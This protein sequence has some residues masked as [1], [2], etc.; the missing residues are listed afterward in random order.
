VRG[1]RREALAARWGQ[2]ALPFYFAE[3]GDEGLEGG[4]GV[5]V[6]GEAQEG[7]RMDGDECGGAV[8][9]G[10]FLAAGIGEAEGFAEDGLGGGDA[11]A[12]DEVGLDGAEFGFEPGATGGDFAGV[13]F[14]ME[15]A[16]AARLPFEVFDG[17]GDVERFAVDAGGA[18]CAIEELAGGADEGFSGA[19]FLVAGLFA[20][21]EDA[22]AGRTL[23]EDRAGGA[24]PEWTCAA[25]RGRGAE[26]REIGGE[27]DGRGGKIG[28]A[29][30]LGFA[31]GDHRGGARG[32]FGEERRD[33][34]GFGEISPVVTRHL[35][36]HGADFDASGVEDAG[37]I[38]APEVFG[39]VGGGSGVAIG[40][41][42]EGER[43]AVPMR[44]LPGRE[45]RP[46]HG[47]EAIDEEGRGGFEDVV[48]RFEPRDEPRAGVGG[49]FAKADERV[50]FVDLAPDGFRHDVERGDVG[51][52]RDFEQVRLAV[53]KTPEHAVEKWPAG[54]VAVTGDVAGEREK[55][56]RDAE[57]GD[58]VFRGGRSV[59][60]CEREFGLLGAAVDP[61]NL[62]GREV[63]REGVAGDGFP[64][65]KRA[66]EREFGHGGGQAET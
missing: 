39:G 30:T 31:G 49:D 7:G 63:L 46:A 64:A 22:G 4:G 35:V 48:L 28:G 38:R 60:G 55:R 61:A 15:T 18:E 11:E 41:G 1:R 19:I 24:A 13:G 62:G 3:V 51:I 40:A 58:F 52:E 20:D 14:L 23:A 27:R 45:D 29:D 17:V 57:G 9:G 47:G 42:G 59:G 56:A 8:G 2:R 34:G 50:G 21:D 32:G 43:V 36:E 16:F 54:F 26:E 25:R 5:G 65:G 6:G 33:R 53:S 44:A 12:D 66:V 37:V 10:K